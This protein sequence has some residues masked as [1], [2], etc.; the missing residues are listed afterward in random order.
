MLLKYSS[1]LG[2]L[3]LICGC[4]S[5]QKKVETVSP[6]TPPSAAAPAP[7][8]P[9][10][11]ESKKNQTTCAQADQVRL[12]EIE[13]L[14]PKGCKVWYSRNGAKN[15]IASSSRG[16]AHCEQVQ[17]N[18]ITKLKDAGFECQ[19]TKDSPSSPAN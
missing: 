8:I 14:Q 3:A 1:L 15:S 5:S 2:C 4:A 12:L 6:Q 10:K 13:I 17:S 11:V 9:L 18:I 7:A 16:N 19:T